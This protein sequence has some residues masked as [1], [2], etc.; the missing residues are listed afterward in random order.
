MKCFIWWYIVQSSLW[1]KLLEVI[2]HKRQSLRLKTGLKPQ[3]GFCRRG[4]GTSNN[5]KTST[6]NNERTSNNE[7]FLI[8]QQY[9]WKSQEQSVICTWKQ[10]L[11][12]PTYKLFFLN[13]FSSNALLKYFGCKWRGHRWPKSL[14]MSSTS[15]FL[16]FCSSSWERTLLP[17]LL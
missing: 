5:E 6:S 13:F 1:T 17:L 11:M 12:Y 8:Y 7:K 2:A 15:M 16:K 3:W 9:F 14:V 10:L 4:V